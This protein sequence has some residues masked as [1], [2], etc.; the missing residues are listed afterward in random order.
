MF[1]TFVQRFLSFLLSFLHSCQVCIPF[2]EVISFY[3]FWIFIRNDKLLFLLC[4]IRY[5]LNS[6]I[7]EGFTHNIF[8]PPQCNK[9]VDAFLRL[10]YDWSKMV[11]TKLI[12]TLTMCTQFLSSICHIPF[13]FHRTSNTHTH[14]HEI[15]SCSYVSRWWKLKQSSSAITFILE[16][17]KSKLLES[18]HLI[19]DLIKDFSVCVLLLL[20]LK[21]NPDEH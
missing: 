1:L 17:N 7:N 16:L 4:F 6:Q 20:L 11:F 10:P 18:Y 8:D 21:R 13:S 12:L 14:T 15:L 2:F 5:C 3:P 9:H 19:N